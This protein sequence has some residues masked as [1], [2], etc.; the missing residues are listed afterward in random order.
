MIVDNHKNMLSEAFRVLQKGGT[1]GFTVW[2]REKNCEFIAVMPAALKAAGFDVPEAKRTLFHLNDTKKLEQDVRDA[3]FDAVKLFYCPIN[4]AF[5]C[6][7]L[8]RFNLNMTSFKG[9]FKDMDQETLDKVRVEFDTI[10]N[11]KFGDDSLLPPTFETIV[12]I[13]RKN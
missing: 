4:P 5:T 2:G 3:G 9:I 6:E 13:A 12:V 11:E 7:E 8:F 10:Y 1:M